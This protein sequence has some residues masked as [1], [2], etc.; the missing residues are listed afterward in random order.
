MFS[1]PRNAD[2]FLMN[3]PWVP[4]ALIGGYLYLVLNLGPKL[5]ANR[6]PFGLKLLMQVY[7]ILQVLANIYLFSEVC[8]Y[9]CAIFSPNVISP[10]DPFPRCSSKRF[11]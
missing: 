8:L 5:M 3:P 10:D 6:K 4:F 2:Q 11:K 9:D 1:D 7:N